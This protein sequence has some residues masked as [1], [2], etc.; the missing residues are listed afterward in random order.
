MDGIYTYKIKF[1]IMLD[2]YFYSEY[3]GHKSNIFLNI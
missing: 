1:Y 3:N 2:M